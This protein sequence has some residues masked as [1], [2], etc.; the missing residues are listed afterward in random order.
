MKAKREREREAE[1]D[2]ETQRDRDRETQSQRER[3]RESQQ[4]AYVRD[5][6]LRCVHCQ[7]D[8]RVVLDVGLA[9]NHIL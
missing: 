7:S 1:K 2:K 3:E 9:V 4:C 8:L 5:I 6:R